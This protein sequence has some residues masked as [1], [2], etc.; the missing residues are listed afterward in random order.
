MEIM[1]NLYGAVTEALG[2]LVEKIIIFAPSLF[3]AFLIFLAGLLIGKAFAWVARR[4]SQRLGIDRVI[5]EAGITESLQANQIKLTPSQIIGKIVFWAIMLLFIM[6]AFDSLGIKAVTESFQRLLA[7]IPNV[8]IAVVIVVIGLFLGKTLRSATSVALNRMGTEFEKPIASFVY[9][10]I[11]LV[12]VLSA[13]R[14]LEI[15]ISAFEQLLF[16][17]GITVA[18]FGGALLAW[19][20]RKSVESTVAGYYL[21]KMLSAEDQIEVKSVQGKIHHIG[22]THTMLE[23]KKGQLLIP[24]TELLDE[25]LNLHQSS[26]S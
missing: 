4:L 15:D 21:R 12:T 18:V 14:Q 5:E 24:N 17:L 3:G 22:S 7:Y 25:S 11:L 6:A 10:A 19:G 23:T 8:L 1:T 20:A 16:L 9:Y 13:F 2:K 26:D